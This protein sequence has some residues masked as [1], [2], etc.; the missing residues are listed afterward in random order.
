[1]ICTIKSAWVTPFGYP[2][3]NGCLL[4]TEAFRS[5]PRPSSPDSSKAST[6]DPYSLDH[7]IL[8]S[9]PYCAVLASCPYFRVAPRLAVLMYLP[10]HCGD[11]TCRVLNYAQSTWYSDVIFNLITDALIKYFKEQME[12]RGLEPR[13]PGLQSRCSSQLSYAP[14]CDTE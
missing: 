14:G 6:M 4:L 2:R 5:L 11:Q 8:I 9:L 13:T 10:V 12:A 7:I 1:M 3:F